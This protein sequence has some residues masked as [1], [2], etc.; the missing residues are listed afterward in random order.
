MRRVD[1][2]L[3]LRAAIAAGAA[4]PFA[5]GENDCCL[6]AARCVD[7]VAG[8][9]WAGALTGAYSTQ[10]GAAR[11]LYR[12]GG[13][14]EAVTRRL[15]HAQLGARARRGDLCLVRTQH[16]PGLGV[17]LGPTLAVMGPDGVDYCA[18]GDA[19]LSWSV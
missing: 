10:R 19:V 16:G 6:F 18:R 9:D 15:G 17:C 14:V 7:A 1:W 3:R 12:E 13:L 11:F 4:C 2:V 5:W 8:T